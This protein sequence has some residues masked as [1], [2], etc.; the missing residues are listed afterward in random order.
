MNINDRIFLRLLE[1]VQSL[2]NVLVSLLNAHLV[3]LAI[4]ATICLVVAIV[5][6]RNKRFLEKTK[7]FW[8]MTLGWSAINL[9]ICGL[10][11]PHKEPEIHA[12]REFLMLNLGLNV[13]YISV[14][15]T[16]GLVKEMVRKSKGAGAAIAVQGVA[17]LLLDGYLMFQLPNH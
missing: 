13:A 16:L 1:P 14:G 2:K 5:S 9:A 15:L 17:L 3:R 4:W 12:L 6:L 7:S 11:I 8:S 10:A